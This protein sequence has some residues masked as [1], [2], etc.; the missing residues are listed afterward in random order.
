MPPDAS[1][2]IRPLAQAENQFLQVLLSGFRLARVGSG[3]C[4]LVVDFDRNTPAIWNRRGRE[5][6]ERGTPDFARKAA[7]YQDEIERFL[8]C[9]EGNE[10][11]YVFQDPAFRFRY[12]GGGA[13]PVIRMDNEDYYALFY[14][15][16]RPIGWNIP[17]GICNSRHEL[18]HPAGMADRELFEE[19]VPVHLDRR[20]R[21]VLNAD[22][23]PSVH[24]EQARSL[25][26]WHE[27]LGADVTS[28]DRVELP[29]KWLTGPDTLRVRVAAEPEQTVRGIFLNI[30]ATDYGIEINRIVKLNLGEGCVLLD[31][32]VAAGR[33]LDRPVGLF[34]VDRFN[35]AL[36]RGATEFRP[37][38]FFHGGRPQEAGDFD[39]ARIAFV[40]HC[41]ADH[42]LSDDELDAYRAEEHK[43]TLCPTTRGIVLRYLRTMGEAPATG[44]DALPDVFISCGGTDW[45]PADRVRTAL[46]GGGHSPFLYKEQFRETHICEAIDQALESARCLVAVATAPAN[47]ARPWT[48]YEI[49]SFLHD[50]NSQRK[51]TGRMLS[52]ISGF[53]PVDLP[54]PLRLYQAIPFDPTNV[55]PALGELAKHIGPPPS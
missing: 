15:E 16:I 51:P 21:Y 44:G 6:I 43:Y 17:S 5:A 35:D 29:V 42:L 28:F 27:R 23:P 1:E 8:L 46:I 24:P 22:A 33:L 54:R 25:A 18:L 30:N 32:E 39:R 3:S 11:A 14:R 13:L 40:E 26:L 50:I 53:D 2:F 48:K 12:C 4:E 49:Y 38:R 7:R 41:C 36:R 9:D 10:P 47:L 45:Q 37:D 52:F 31:G 20:E 55:E 19:L 34:R